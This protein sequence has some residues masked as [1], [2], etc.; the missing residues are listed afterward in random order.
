MLTRRIF[1]TAFAACGLVFPVLAQTPSQPVPVRAVL[2]LFT[3]QGCSSCPPADKLFMKLSR[4]PGVI[5]LSMPV[6]IWDY[7]GWKD[8]LA[9]HGFTMRQ[10]FYGK[11]RGDRHIYTPQAVVNGAAHAVGSDFHA[12]NTAVKSSSEA[13][14]V[15]SL[16]V[17]LQLSGDEWAVTVAAGGTP[18]TVYLAAFERHKTIEIGRGENTGRSVTYA[19]VVRDFVKIGDYS[20]E[21][22]AAP[23]KGARNSIDEGFAILVQS[24]SERRPGVILGAVESPRPV[25]AQ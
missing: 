8:T 9:Q 12:I 20:G 2:E 15:L 10:R 3:S 14:G 5:A 24:G 4:E 7:L 16:P 18:G 17:A 23:L 1:A 11:A 19:N 6:T 21:A 25:S 22:F 13:P